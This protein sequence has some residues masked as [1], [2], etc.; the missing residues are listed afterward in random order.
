MTPPFVFYWRLSWCDAF[1]CH[2]PN[3]PFRTFDACVSAA[4]M[5]IKALHATAWCHGV[6]LYGVLP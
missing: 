2:Y 3:I 4:E 5:V 1:Q 6:S